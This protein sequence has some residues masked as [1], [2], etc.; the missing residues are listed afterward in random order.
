M[1]LTTDTLTVTGAA[2]FGSINAQPRST[3][4]QTPNAV[5]PIEWGTLRVWDAYATVLPSAAAND[6][7]GLTGGT[8][9]TDPPEVNAGDCG[10]L[11]TTTRYARFMVA[12][13]ECYQ[14]AETVSIRFSAGMVTTVADASCVID[15]ECFQI[16]RVTGIS[17]DLCATASQSM[18]SL[19]FADIAFTITPTALEPGDI[20]DCRV[21]IVC[22]DAGTGPVVQPTIGAI[23]LLCD[24]QA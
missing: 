6:D 12:L 19:S 18:N 1:P 5:F 13:P 15:L 8:W 22:V 7:L 10:A 20:L 11:G 24:I 17:A 9:A 21:K 23:E 4:T 2:R 14:A 16:D 3:I